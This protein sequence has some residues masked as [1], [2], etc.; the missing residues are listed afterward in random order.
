[1]PE[2]HH[3]NPPDAIDL[4][5]ESYDTLNAWLMENPVIQTEQQAKE[6]KLLVDRVKISLDEV[7]KERDG[8]VRPLN[9]QVRGIN[10]RYKNA[11]AP[12]SKIKEALIGRL[13][14]YALALER[15]RLRVA[16]ETRLAAEKAEAAAR[17]AERL[18][19]EAKENAAAGELGVSIADATT[20]ADAAFSEYQKASREAARAQ[21]DTKV[22]VTGGFS[23]AI[24]L[25]EKET[26]VLEDVS[27]VLSFME[28]TPDI[29]EAVLKAARAYRKIHGELP[30]GISA[31]FERTL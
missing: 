7:E 8:L 20:L 16:E 10:E 4:M 28:I 24:G 22:K 21:R 9:S 13:S 23:R 12:V 2:A 5:L 26:L 29:T 18:E 27:L 17:E 15:E 11:V 3:N 6:G 31:T 19:K 1:M 14:D 25:K 30:P